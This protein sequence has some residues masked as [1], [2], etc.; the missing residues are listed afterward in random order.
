VKGLKV[1]SLPTAAMLGVIVVCAVVVGGGGYMLLV[2]PEKNRTASIEK[3]IAAK[4]ATIAQYKAE[5]ATHTGS[6]AIRI[7]DVY[8]LAQA[9]PA[10]LDMPDVL[11]E[12]DQVARD[13]GITITSIT[14]QS[15]TTE[16]SYEVVPIALEFNGDYYSVTDLLYRL[17][18]L[19]SVRHGQLD[20]NGRLYG[21]NSIA[22]QPDGKQLRATVT[23][24]TYVYGAGTAGVATATP[25]TTDTTATSTTTDSTPTDSSS[26]SSSSATGGSATGAP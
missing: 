9:M 7:A 10:T 13:A 22:L 11:L 26:S 4:Q 25:T 3:Q 6:P 23:V 16:G 20:A 1:A 14:P 18:T 21:I 15:P 8:R 2:K 12:L 19:V 5:S 17:R 24:D